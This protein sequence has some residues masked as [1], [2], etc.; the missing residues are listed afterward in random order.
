[1]EKHII[2]NGCKFTRDEKTGY[3]LKSTKPRKRLKNRV[4]G[5]PPDMI[6]YM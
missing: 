5:L 1:M 3:Y 4:D 2:F 6:E